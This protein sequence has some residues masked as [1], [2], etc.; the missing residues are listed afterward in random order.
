MWSKKKAA[1]SPRPALD[2]LLIYYRCN[3]LIEQLCIPT[4][5]TAGGFGKIKPAWENSHSKYLRLVGDV[6][7]Q[8]LTV[9]KDVGQQ[10]SL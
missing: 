1:V 9:K 3:F 5:D 4:L 6:I 7:G 10:K 2:H 8:T